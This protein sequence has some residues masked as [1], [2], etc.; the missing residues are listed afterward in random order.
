MLYLLICHKYTAL[1]FP[2]HCGSD[3]EVER[4][5]DSVIGVYIGWEIT[6]YGPA[7]QDMSLGLF[8]RIEGDGSGR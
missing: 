8:I 7:C 5:R 2:S 6:T 1:S 4:N 3:T